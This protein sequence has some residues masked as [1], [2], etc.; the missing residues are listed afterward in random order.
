MA[1]NNRKNYG[2]QRLCSFL[3]QL[4]LSPTGTLLTVKSWRYPSGYAFLFSRDYCR[5]TE[6]QAKSLNFRSF[7]LAK[8]PGGLDRGW[9]RT[10]T[11]ML[12]KSVAPDPVLSSFHLGIS[13]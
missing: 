12:D 6:E 7:S 2:I 13:V 8:K 10:N 5:K 11:Q 1:V 9:L 4:K 3:F